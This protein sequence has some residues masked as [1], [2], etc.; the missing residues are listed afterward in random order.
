M[1]HVQV[2][3]KCDAGDRIRRKK[4]KKKTSVMSLKGTVSSFP[5][6]LLSL[7]LRPKSATRDFTSLS[8]C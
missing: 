7:Q 3:K 8:L 6:S 4:K 5:R 2:D 1:Y